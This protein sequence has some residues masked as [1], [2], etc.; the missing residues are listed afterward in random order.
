MS[1]EVIP[2]IDVADGKLVRMSIGGPSAVEAFGADPVAAV[3]A[4]VEAGAR[5][6]HVVDVDFAFTGQ[7]CNLDVV[8]AIHARHPDVSIQASGGLV[9]P[10][11]VRRYLDVGAARAVLG[12]AALADRAATERLIDARGEA[13]VVGIETR[14][15]RIR[16]RGRDE[17]IDLDLGETLAWLGEARP[18]R[19]L[20]TSVRRV[21]ALSGPDLGGLR[22]V[23]GVGCPVIAAGG[24][25]SGADLAAVR[26]AGA[27]GVVVGRAALEGSID[28]R[29]ALRDSA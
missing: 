26:D 19:C 27:E 7:S 24:I 3:Q 18:A 14:G 28:L 25:A 23:I 22:I 8:R 17:A 11:D 16:P 10:T 9:R 6:L 13:L 21:G 4:Y 1:F 29:A 2:A 15:G 20:H 5:W 12:S